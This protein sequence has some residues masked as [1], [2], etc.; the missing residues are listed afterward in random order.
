MIDMYLKGVLDIDA[1]SLIISINDI[2][3]CTSLKGLE[4]IS[5]DLLTKGNQ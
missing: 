3:Y 2:T 5:K 1:E 4:T